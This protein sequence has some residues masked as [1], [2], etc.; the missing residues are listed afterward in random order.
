MGLVTVAEFTASK[1]SLCSFIK[2][3]MNYYM[4]GLN[5]KIY[6]FC[7]SAWQ[8]FILYIIIKKTN[9]ANSNM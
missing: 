5:L 8:F 3:V 6:I 1:L 7:I 4:L 2:S 9:T